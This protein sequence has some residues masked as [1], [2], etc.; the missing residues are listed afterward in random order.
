MSTNP[1]EMYPRANFLLVLAVQTF[2]ASFVVWEE[3]QTFRQLMLS[4]G[5]QFPS[6]AYDDLGVLV[7]VL[8]MQAVYW[9]RRLRVPMPAFN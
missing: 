9:Y 7:T 5:E 8:V 2:G 4:P 3:L 1:T 6:I